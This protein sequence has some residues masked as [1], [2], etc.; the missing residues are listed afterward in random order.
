MNG[1]FSFARFRGIIATSIVACLQVLPCQ[2]Q[3]DSV[4]VASE[5]FRMSRLIIPSALVGIGTWGVWNGWLK[6]VNEEVKDGM[7]H[8]RGQ[9]YHHVDDY[10]QYVPIIANV[11]LKW[12]V[13]H[14]SHPFRER[15]ATTA[16][17]YIALGVMV[18]ITKPLIGE[19]RPDTGAR[20]SFPSGH[21]ATAFMGAELVRL[22]YGGCY[23]A[24][25]Y[26]WAT[27]IAFLRMYNE[28]HWLNDVIAGAGI[29]I[30]SAELGHWLLPLERKFFGWNKKKKGKDVVFA[31]ISSFHVFGIQGFMNI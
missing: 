6:S 8:L 9:C 20:T 30:L 16:T 26:G 10:L 4:R 7:A 3:A 19:R 25:A 15:V 1:F 12:L 18:N 27:G 29:G 28:R 17:A 5:Q 24:V 13:P 2:A 14:G 23:G 21:T 31:P 22:E 11:G